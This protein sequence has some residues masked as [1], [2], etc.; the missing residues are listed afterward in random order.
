MLRIVRTRVLLAMHSPCRLIDRDML[1]LRDLCQTFEH[2]QDVRKP[3]AAS[4]HV[5]SDEPGSIF[6]RAVYYLLEVLRPKAK[7]S[8]D[9]SGCVRCRGLVHVLCGDDRHIS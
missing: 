2:L 1:V 8:L 5:Q 6:A 4:D 7:L 9:P 3:A